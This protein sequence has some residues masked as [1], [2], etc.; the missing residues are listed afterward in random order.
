MTPSRP[1]TKQPSTSTTQGRPGS[2]PGSSSPGQLEPAKVGGEVVAGAGPAGHHAD[3]D[4]EDVQLV[5][6]ARSGH[7]EAWEMLI[8]KHQD[9]LYAMCVRM[10][11][12]RELAQDLTHDAFV[13]IIQGIDS[14][15]GRARLTTWMTRIAMNVC[16]SK[17]RSEKLRRHPSL[18]AMRDPDARSV[19]GG[20]GGGGVGGAG[21]RARKT[22]TGGKGGQEGGRGMEF[23]QT[24]EPD[25]VGRVEAAEE[26]DRLL[27]AL[28][29]LDPE[30]RQVLILADQQQLGYEQIADVL[31]VAVGTVK[32]RVFRAR[33]AL[34]A[35]IEAASAEQM[36]ERANEYRSRRNDDEV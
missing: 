11:R 10:V 1:A 8:R 6:S 3:D 35:A 24:R 9:R 18:D 12:D 31:G 28:R 34:R 4:P 15:D 32:S 33:A 36:N 27:E 14:F 23:Q 19:G 29:G 22:G 30:Q 21:G 20:G 25:G 5:A 7:R 13:K 26:R 2:A 17:L 16:L